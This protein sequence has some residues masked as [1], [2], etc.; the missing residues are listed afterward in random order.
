MV[1]DHLLRQELASRDLSLCEC[2]DHHPILLGARE[3][4][5]SFHGSFNPAEQIS[6]VKETISDNS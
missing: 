4:E 5:I 1:I 6:L 3:V 2:D